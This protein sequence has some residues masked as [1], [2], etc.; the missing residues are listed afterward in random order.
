MPLRA[1][2]SD[3]AISASDPVGVCTCRSL[4]SATAGPTTLALDGSGGATGLAGK[5]DFPTATPTGV[6]TARGAGGRLGGTETGVPERGLVRDAASW[7]GSPAARGTGLRIAAD[8][9]SGTAVGI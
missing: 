1:S 3:D 7:D 2:D 4:G 5:A 9:P 6:K 8:E